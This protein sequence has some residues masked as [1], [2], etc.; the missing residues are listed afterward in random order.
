MIPN[1]CSHPKRIFW[2]PIEVCPKCEPDRCAAL[3]RDGREPLARGVANDDDLANYNGG[4][5]GML[6]IFRTRSRAH[7]ETRILILPAKP[8]GEA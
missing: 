1:S 3:E 8:E 6:T 4:K 5:L 7:K 2:R